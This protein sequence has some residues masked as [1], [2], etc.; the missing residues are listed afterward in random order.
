MKHIEMKI[1]RS[2]KMIDVYKKLSY[3]KYILN[4]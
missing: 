4:V 3:E 2:N 1:Y